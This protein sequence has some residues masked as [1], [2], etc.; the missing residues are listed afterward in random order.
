MSGNHLLSQLVKE[1]RKEELKSVRGVLVASTKDLPVLT[2]NAMSLT[3][4]LPM[5]S[6]V[7]SAHCASIR[8]KPIGHYGLAEN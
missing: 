3:W 4:G 6:W 7:G 5:A 1:E 2:Y 8:S